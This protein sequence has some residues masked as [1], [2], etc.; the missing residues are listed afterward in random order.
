MNT[1]I[2]ASV[3]YIRVWQARRMRVREQTHSNNVP[4]L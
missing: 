4:R 2:D 3:R 1:R